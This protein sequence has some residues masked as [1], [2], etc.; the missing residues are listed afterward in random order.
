MKLWKDND[1]DTAQELVSWLL[2]TIKDGGGWSVDWVNMVAIDELPALSSQPD[3]V[4]YLFNQTLREMKDKGKRTL[5]DFEAI[6]EVA[7]KARKAASRSQS[8]NSWQFFI[9]INIHVTDAST[10]P[11]RECESWEMSLAS[12][13]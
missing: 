11:S 7:L 8:T 4:N 12:L 9:P 3:S 13:H 2:S 5:D 1:R 10:R 6:F